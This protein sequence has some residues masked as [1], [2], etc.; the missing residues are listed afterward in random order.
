MV[1]KN[2][3]IVLFGVSGGV[4]SSYVLSLVKK[5]GLTL[6]WIMDGIQS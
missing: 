4:D 1:L 5:E 3:M 2:L 6:T